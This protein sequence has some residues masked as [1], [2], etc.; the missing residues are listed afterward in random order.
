M[1]TEVRLVAAVGVAVG[2][3]AALVLLLLSLQRTVDS[4]V[5]TVDE[6]VGAA[7]HVIGAAVLLWYLATAV[8]AVACLCA[9]AAGRARVATERRLAAMGA[10]LVRRLL[11]AGTGALVTTAA[12]LAPAGAV[13]TGP[14][15]AVADDLGWGASSSESDGQPGDDEPTPDEAPTDEQTPDEQPAD[16]QPADGPG[17][18]TAIPASVPDPPAPQEQE[19]YTVEGGDSLWAIAAEHLPGD[20]DAADIAAAWP[21]WFDINR[22]VIGDDPDVIHPGQVLLVPDHDLEEKA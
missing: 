10:P 11:V 16:E 5:T 15:P 22:D 19:S 2:S 18:G 4:G 6:A 12:V 7:V 3:A 17:A 9:R 13:P 21:L 14:S 20:A 1:G 8:V